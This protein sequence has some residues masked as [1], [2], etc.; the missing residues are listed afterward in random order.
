MKKIM[1]IDSD[2]L[3]LKT[4]NDGLSSSFQ[5]LNCSRGAK[6]MDLYRIFLPNALILDPTTPGLPESD[7]IH[8]VRNLPG[9]YRLPIL[10]LTKIQSTQTLD[11]IFRWKVDVVLS[12]PCSAERAE[13]K[14]RE[15][16]TLVPVE[17]PP[18]VARG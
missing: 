2:V 6:A 17:H 5:V 1:L 11:E 13:K 14:L 3:Q 16:L 4:L 12:K 7:F 10:A 9:G 8:S 15:L 18:I